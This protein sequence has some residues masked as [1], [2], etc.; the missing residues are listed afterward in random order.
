MKFEKA[1][2][3]KAKLRLMI[4]SPSGGGKTYT[5]LRVGQELGERI[6]VIDTE[7]ES[8][9]KYAD[10]FEFDAL[11]LDDPTIPHYQDAIK[12]AGD[13]GYDVVIVDSLSHAWQ[14]ALAEVDRVAIANKTGNSFAAWGKVTPLWDSLLR[15]VISC[16]AHIICTARSKTEYVLEEDQR[17]KKIP[18]KVGMAPQLRDGAEYEFDVV[19]DMDIQN[20]LIVQKTRCKELVGKVFPKP[21]PEFAAILKNWLNSGSDPNSAVA[22][23]VVQEIANGRSD[24]FIRWL[25]DGKADSLAAATQTE[26]HA[27]RILELVELR[28]GEFPAWDKQAGAA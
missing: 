1:T 25:T 27:A 8:A 9:S 17:G 4:M 18:K 20:N 7:H 6:A 12:L 3:K 2:K 13:S 21:G 22:A 26:K 23:R 19:G 14:Y 16:R 28:R 15:S 10:E 5:A 24:E 11:N